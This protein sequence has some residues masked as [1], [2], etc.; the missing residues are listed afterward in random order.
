[1]FS[2]LLNS[3]SCDNLKI[4]KVRCIKRSVSIS[5]SYTNT[6][7]N[8]KLII[9]GNKQERMIIKELFEGPVG[10]YWLPTILSNACVIFKCNWNC[11]CYKQLFLADNED[12]ARKILNKA[13]V[14][15]AQ[16]VKDIEEALC[17]L[18]QGERTIFTT[19]TRTRHDF[20]QCRYLFVAWTESWGFFPPGIFPSH[21]FW[22]LGVIPSHG[23]SRWKNNGRE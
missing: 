17:R 21:Y 23:F 6:D 10:D 3:G 2:C 13:L 4:I 9:N 5:S 20:D 18:R 16:P 12:R 19:P 15:E 8:L 11:Y 7:F 14:F 1:M 22:H